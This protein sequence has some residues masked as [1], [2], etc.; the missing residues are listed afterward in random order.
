MLEH[1]RR[2]Y[3]QQIVRAAISSPP[4]RRSARPC[5]WRGRP[6]SGKTTHALLIERELGPPRHG[7]AHALHG[8]LFL[9]AHGAG[10]GAFQAATSWTSSAPSRVDVPFFQEQLGKLLAGEEVELPHYDF[11]NSVRVFDGRTLR[12]RPG[13]LVI[14]EG[15]HALNPEVT[16]YDGRTTRI[17]VS[18][19]HAHHPAQRP[20][21]PSVEDPSRPPYAAR[22]HGPRAAPCRDHRHARARRPRR[23]ALYHALQAARPRQH[24]LVLFHRARRLPPAAAG[25]SGAPCPA[26][27]V[28]YGRGHAGAAG[29]PGGSRAAGFPPARIHR[30]AA[31]LLTEEEP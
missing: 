24:R 23:A 10:A 11:K 21:A 18:V 28:R 6:G 26:G 31:R 1:D 20:S 30:R 9:P 16:G 4:M 12:R 25:R 2:L 19:R 15:I 5:C 7:D 29:R 27:A 13:E 22:Q 8:R 14:L 17:Y 3:E